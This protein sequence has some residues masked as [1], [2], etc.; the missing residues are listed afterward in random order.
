MNEWILPIGG[1]SAVEGLLSTGPTLSSFQSSLI[2]RAQ[3]QAQ[4][5]K[6][7]RLYSPNSGFELTGSWVIDIIALLCRAK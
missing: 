7:D 6:V 3:G 5:K 4:A 2:C 1:A